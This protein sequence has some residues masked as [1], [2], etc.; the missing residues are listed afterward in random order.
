[1]SLIDILRGELPPPKIT[2]SVRRHYDDPAMQEYEDKVLRPARERHRARREA[3]PQAHCDAAKAWAKANPEKAK[4]RRENWVKNNP[5]RA[6]KMQ[7]AASR[8][9]WQ[10]KQAKKLAKEA[11]WTAT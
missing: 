2:G 11:S 7:R 9:Y 8:R 5:E 10:K 1:M 6:K 4:K 3:D